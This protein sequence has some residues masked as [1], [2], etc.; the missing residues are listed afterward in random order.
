MHGPVTAQVMMTLEER[1]EDAIACF[2]HVLSLAG[3]GGEQV[4]EPRDI[5]EVGYA[6]TAAIR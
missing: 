4:V 2:L 5:A 6:G 1:F 3:A